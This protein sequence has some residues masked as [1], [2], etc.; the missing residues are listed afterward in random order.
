MKELVQTHFK[1]CDDRL[2]E[3]LLHCIP[4]GYRSTGRPKRNGNISL[5]KKNKSES[6]TFKAEEEEEISK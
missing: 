2:Q 4:G 3:I 5:T 6:P 1:H